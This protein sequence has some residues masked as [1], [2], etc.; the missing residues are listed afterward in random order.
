[1]NRIR[2]IAMQ[3]IQ[4]FKSGLQ[5]QRGCEFYNAI[6]YVSIDSDGNAR[7]SMCS[8]I[9]H[10][11]TEAI[12]ILVRDEIAYTNSY[13]WYTVYYITNNGVVLQ[14]FQNGKFKITSN[15]P[16]KYIDQYISLY[17]ENKIIYT[18][19]IN[20]S[21]WTNEFLKLWEAFKIAKRYKT[22]DEIY[23]SVALYNKGIQLIKSNERIDE[24]CQREKLLDYQIK[25]YRDILN[26]FKSLLNTKNGN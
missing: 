10:N 1:M 11:A 4:D 18:F 8:D 21:T 3:V 22:S 6:M 14:N 13:W 12:L 24:L 16:N 5:G 7:T 9:L 23:L 19:L 2:E 20:H 17:Y 26:Q 25:E 15:C